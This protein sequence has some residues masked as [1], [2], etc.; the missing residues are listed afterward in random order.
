MYKSSGTWRFKVVFEILL[1]IKYVRLLNVIKDFFG[2]GKIYFSEKKA[3]FRVSNT[4]D[5]MVIIN[6]FNLFPLLTF[7]LVT[8]K[9]WAEVV[10][11][12]HN[13][14]HLVPATFNYIMTIYAA[15]GRGASV[16]VMQAFPNLTAIALPSYVLTVTK[17]MLNPW[18]INGYLTLY[19]SFDLKVLGAGWKES[20]YNKFRA[21]FSFSFKIENLP[22][23]E[24]ISSYLGI[25]MHIRSD[26][27]RV[28]AMGQSLDHGLNIINF[29]D[30]YPLQSYKHQHYE[31]FRDFVRSL[32]EDAFDQVQRKKSGHVDRFKYYSTLSRILSELK[33][34][35]NE[36]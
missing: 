2:V 7:K 15:L 25:R 17:D 18:W 30:N 4:R 36:K 32:D 28:D 6:H 1:D 12:M 27:T 35:R 8:F 9:L 13:S 20:V 3:T 11:L 19:C 29:M 33:A 5:L 21:V 23:A 31:I 10:T 34:E 26:G 14:E 22:V 16:S 24:L